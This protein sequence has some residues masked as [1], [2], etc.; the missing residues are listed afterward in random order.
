MTDRDVAPQ[1]PRHERQVVATGPAIVDP[2]IAITVSHGSFEQA[3]YALM[4][5]T[6][7]DEFFT[8]AERLLDVQLHGVLNASLEAGIYPGPLEGRSIFIELSTDEHTETQPPG[9]Y[10]VGLG[11]TTALTR[12]RLTF[13]V[14]QALINRC[15]HLYSKGLPVD[16]QSF[17]KVGVSSTLMG[18]RNDEGLRIRESVAGIVAGVL[19]ANVALATYESSR[20]HSGDSVPGRVRIAALEFVERFSDRADIAAVAVRSLQNMVRLPDGYT[21]ALS[22]VTVKKKRGA[23]PPGAA[24]TA[25]VHQEWRRFSITSTAGPPDRAGTVTFDISFQGDSARADRTTH[26]LDPVVLDSLAKRLST[27]TE[28]T[29]GATALYDVLVPAELREPFQS[30]SL[31]QLVVDETSANYPWELL[32]TPRMRGQAPLAAQKAVIRQ[33]SEIGL[34]RQAPIRANR[35]TALVIAA[36]SAVPGSPLNGVREEADVV[37]TQLRRRFPAGIVTVMDDAERRLSTADLVIAL[38]GDHQILHIASHGE[39][40]PNDPTRT[41]ALLNAEFRLRA[42]TVQTIQRVPELV[43]LNC[44]SLGQI[45]TGHLAAG[46]ARAFMAIGARAVIAAG[47]RVDDTAAKTFADKFYENFLKGESFGDSVAAARHECAKKGAHETWAAYQCYG[48]P[49]YVLGGGIAATPSSMGTPVGFDD[50]IRRLETLQT[51]AAD[52]GRPGIDRLNERRWQLRKSYEHLAA[53]ANVNGYAQFHG[54]DEDVERTVRVQ[55]LLARVASYIGEF[56]SA[57]E[58]FV[59]LV[60]VSETTTKDASHNRSRWFNVEDM[61]QA[62]NCLSRAALHEW[63]R[64]SNPTTRA[65]LVQELKQAVALAEQARDLIAENES[66]S[67]LGGALKRLAVTSSGAEQRRLVARAAA[68]YQGKDARPDDAIDIARSYTYRKHNAYQLAVLLG[69]TKDTKF[70]RPPNTQKPVVENRLVDQTRVRYV[71]YWDA[72]GPGDAA[73]TD[74]LT[75]PSESSRANLRQKMVDAY[76]VAFE[77]R[78]TWRERAST[79]DH[80]RDL[81]DLLPDG[82]ERRA[83]LDTALCEFKRWE[84]DNRVGDRSDSLSLQTPPDL[85]ES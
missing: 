84:D 26:S 37:T 25:D 60:G 38:H 22:A 56:R 35:E 5:P 34:R 83:Q 36:G 24:L 73:L 42:D 54:S 70:E 71:E 21:D 78:S 12:D 48:D 72:S 59:T 85:V 47:W 66:N 32:S 76:I 14:R 7:E 64:E 20:E 3:D 62:S 46:L 80:L 67:I 30:I 65:K 81:H 45:G 29:A 19:E 39:F 74:L 57:A 43:F 11:R 6:Y 50:L 13:A 15:T 44:C 55:R 53:W 82:D 17:I 9:A 52:L 16:E 58:R 28:D 61:Q 40:Q 75:A 77:G 51:R 31:L 79:I 41:G 18:V 63:R 49:S 2:I 4:V 23:L 68:A 33:F 10:I 8:G 69:P 1:H 27:D